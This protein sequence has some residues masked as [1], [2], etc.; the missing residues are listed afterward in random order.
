MTVL[1]PLSSCDLPVQRIFEHAPVVHSSSFACVLPVS[2]SATPPP[3]SPAPSAHARSVHILNFALLHF[4]PVPDY[5][6]ATLA[7]PPPKTPRSP[8]PHLLTSTRRQKFDSMYPVHRS[9]FTE[10]IRSI[11]IVRSF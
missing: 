5:A 4:P 2:K 3:S 6:T 9:T 10:E 8:S 1:F 11:Y 7:H